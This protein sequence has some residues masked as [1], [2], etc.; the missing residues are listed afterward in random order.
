MTAIFNPYAK[1]DEGNI[2]NEKTKDNIIEIEIEKLIPFKE[3]PFNEYSES[4]MKELKDSINRIGLQNAIIVRRIENEKYQILSGHNRVRAFE[5]LG[6]NTILCKV[7]EVDD[8]TAEMILI[9]TNIVQR[10][11]LSVM[12]RARAFKRK[13]EIKKRRKYNID[14]VEE[15]LSEEEKNKLSIT[16][17]R[18]T[19]YRY[20]SLNNLIPEYQEQCEKGKLPVFSGEHLSKLSEEQQRR[21]LEV[22]GNVTI[23]EAKAN[24]LKKLFQNNNECSNEEIRK[25]YSDKKKDN[26]TTVK[27][28]KKE[29][30]IFFKQFDTSEQV[31]Q[32]IIELIKKDKVIEN[33]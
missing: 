28:S 5:E 27:F 32:Y 2:E 14:Q 15:N 33:I 25:V 19:F 20:L 13:D 22:L 7:I 6:F 9:D 21:I 31:K 3:Q 1:F 11:G 8:D 29:S 12:E 4:E 26:K 30:E 10:N 24:E 23:K 16:E 17:A 18:Q